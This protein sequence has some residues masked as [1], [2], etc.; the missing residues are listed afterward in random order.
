MTP[1][2]ERQAAEAQA[3]QMILDSLPQETDPNGQKV[4]DILYNIYTQEM[5]IITRLLAKKILTRSAATSTT[6]YNSIHKNSHEVL[7]G[8]ANGVNLQKS[9]NEIEESLKNS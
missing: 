9:A 6:I 4:G 8:I 1:T 3:K 5:N 7:N 2:K